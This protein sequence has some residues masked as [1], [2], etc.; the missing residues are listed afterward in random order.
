MN[1]YQ[2]LDISPS[3]TKSEIKKAYYKKAKECHPDYFPNDKQKEEQFK[4]INQAYQALM[5]NNGNFW[6]KYYYEQQR[7]EEFLQKEQERKRK[8]QERKSAYYKKQKEEK[9]KRQSAIE[10]KTKKLIHLV[11]IVIFCLTAV[12]CIV[13]T[14]QKEKQ[15]EMEYQLMQN[16]MYREL[17]NLRK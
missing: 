11:L 15:E 5:N 13:D 4:I 14:I 9:Q 10:E 16:I 3:S 12:L 1:Y 8:E 7:E 6:Q 2:I 17:I